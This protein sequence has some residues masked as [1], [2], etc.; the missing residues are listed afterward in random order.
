MTGEFRLLDCSF[1]LNS[2]D[3][4]L[5]DIGLSVELIER[6]VERRQL[7]PLW[8]I[9]QAHWHEVF[10]GAQ[11]AGEHASKPGQHG[12]AD[13]DLVH[14]SLHSPGALRFGPLQGD[15]RYLRA[16]LPFN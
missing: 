9:A 16:T 1:A 3:L 2:V 12:S 6:A 7:L 13:D 8:G 5:I 10:R 11:W 4:R 15:Y 14:L